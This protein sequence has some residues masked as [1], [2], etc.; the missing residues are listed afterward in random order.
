MSCFF[1]FSALIMALTLFPRRRQQ[2]SR[3]RCIA[4]RRA[5][6]LAK[7]RLNS[8]TGHSL[9]RSLAWC[10]HYGIAAISCDSTA[11]DFELVL[12]CQSSYMDFKDERN[13]KHGTA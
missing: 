13:T 12:L 2:V 11:R 7:S 4:T 3:Y 5:K 10:Q 6:F 8:G 9:D 1:T